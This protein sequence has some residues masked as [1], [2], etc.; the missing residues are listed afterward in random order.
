MPQKNFPPNLN[1]A[2]PFKMSSSDGQQLFITSSNIHLGDHPW[3]AFTPGLPRYNTTYWQ[4]QVK[5]CDDSYSDAIEMHPK[6]NSIAKASYYLPN[7][8]KRIICQFGMAIQ[9]VNPSANG[10]FIGRILIDG[11]EIWSETIKGTS[12]DAQLFSIDKDFSSIT[13]PKIIEF[14]VGSNGGNEAD[15]AVWLAPILRDN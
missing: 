13:N 9:D 2:F 4:E 14:Q 15:H 11:T 8:A 6:P 1:V 10:N 7:N 5:I 12:C 3:K